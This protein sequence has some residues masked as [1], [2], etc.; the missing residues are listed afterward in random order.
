VN[1]YLVDTNVF[2]YA[3]GKDHPYRDPCRAVL[4]AAGDRHLVLEAS[5]E[6]VQEYAHILLRRGVDRSSAL[7]EIDEVRSQCRLHAFDVAVLM[8]ATRLLR[9]Y[10][11]LGVRDAVHAATAVQAGLTQVLSADHV[12]DVVEEVTR[13]DPAQPDAHWLQ[14]H[15]HDD[16]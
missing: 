11:G 4:R 10:E 9:Q 1:H 12:F 14:D 2:L 15:W 6:V 8:H 13:V 5:V 3:R 7:E 16:S